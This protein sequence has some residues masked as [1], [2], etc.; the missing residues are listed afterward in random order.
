MEWKQRFPQNIKY[1]YNFGSRLE[2]ILDYENQPFDLL[3]LEYFTGDTSIDI[4]S[5]S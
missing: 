4:H 2:N 3:E 5:L 1:Y